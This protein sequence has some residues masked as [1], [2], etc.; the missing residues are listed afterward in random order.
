MSQTRQVT[1]HYSGLTTT[2]FHHASTRTN[3]AA[4]LKALQLEYTKLQ[5]EPVEG[6]TVKLGDD[7]NLFNWHGSIDL[8]RSY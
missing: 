8:Y 5:K 1:N 3:N 4:S 6:F 7:G 2:N